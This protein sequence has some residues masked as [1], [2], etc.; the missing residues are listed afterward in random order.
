[1]WKTGLKWAV[2]AWAT[3]V[4]SFAVT[5]MI[6]FIGKADPL[7]SLAYT[8]FVAA[9]AAIISPIFIVP[10][11][12]AAALLE[13]LWPGKPSR[14]VQGAIV[15]FVALSWTR[16]PTGMLI[17]TIAGGTAGW[18]GDRELPLWSRPWSIAVGLGSLMGGVA[19]LL[20]GLVTA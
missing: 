7:A 6:M 18:V 9:F 13:Y 1:M 8:L 5:L 4:P 10:T 12:A 11:A 2:S 17:A 14:L 15:G 20:A 19:G 16:W 3:T